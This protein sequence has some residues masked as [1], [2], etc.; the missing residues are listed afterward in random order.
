VIPLDAKAETRD[1]RA[2]GCLIEELTS[3]LGERFPVSMQNWCGIGERPYVLPFWEV[4]VVKC[5]DET[6]GIAGLYR[7][8]EDPR[9]RCWIGWL[10]VRPGYRCR[11]IAQGT[12]DELQ[13]LASGYGFKELWVH[14][15]ENNPAAAALYDSTSFSLISNVPSLGRG[16]SSDP[17]GLVFRCRLEAHTA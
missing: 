3:E 6:V 12:V 14:T 17:Q 8:N 4:Y 9:D 2:Y 5:D 10:G 15:D 13:R 11:G 7:R 16:R 1:F